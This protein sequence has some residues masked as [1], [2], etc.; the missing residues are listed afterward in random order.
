VVS[1][2]AHILN[3][4]ADFGKIITTA[5]SLLAGDDLHGHPKANLLIVATIKGNIE[6]AKFWE[7]FNRTVLDAKDSSGALIYPELKQCI[8]R[9]GG[10][11]VWKD[12]TIFKLEEQIRLYDDGSSGNM[13]SYTESDIQHLHGILSSQKWEEIKP[14]WEF[15]VVQNCFPNSATN[16]GPHTTINRFCQRVKF[17]N[18]LR[19]YPRRN[20]ASIILQW[21]S[22]PFRGAW[23]ISECILCSFRHNDWIVIAADQFETD[24]TNILHAVSQPLAIQSIKSIKN[25]FNVSFASVL[26]SVLTGVHRRMLNRKGFQVPKEVSF[27][28]T[29]PLRGHSLKLT[30]HM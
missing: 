24:N 14:L 19:S 18:A 21:A 9:W 28:I 26:N 17:T 1:Y 25:H 8:R 13:R 6:V 20:V 16:F 4:D 22:F 15:V 27:W 7:L 2:T 5:S 29:L 3:G 30:K 10:Y 11:F 12:C 23:A